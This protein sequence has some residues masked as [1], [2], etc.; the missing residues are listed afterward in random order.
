MKGYCY[1]NT[2]RIS[3]LIL[4][5]LVPIFS[6]S[7]SRTLAEFGVDIQFTIAPDIFPESW[8]TEKI[9]G[10]ATPLDSIEIERTTR[11]I[12]KALNKYPTHLI[13]KNLTKIY[14]VKN[15]EFY[16]LSYGGTSS[17]SAVYIS[18]NGVS[19]GYTDF[20]IEQ[21][22]HTEFSSILLRNYSFLLNSKKWTSQSKGIKYGYSGVE[23]LQNGKDSRE[24][25]LELNKKGFLFMYGTA[26]FEEDFN[27]FAEN[28]FLCSRGFWS[29]VKTQKR[30]NAK[31]LMAISFYNSIDETFTESY[32]RTISNE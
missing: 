30:I 12:L 32:F 10:K 19:S 2:I 8:L 6:F 25:D 29:I 22:F 11:I 7:Q 4:I 13:K 18:N 5:S 24:F 16:G 1:F 31:A 15:L 14:A 23:A 17:T 28:L 21:T 27:S 3:S 9:N 20:W 26:S